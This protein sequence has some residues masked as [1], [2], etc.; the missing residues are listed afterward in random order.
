MFWW[1]TKTQR[2]ATQHNTTQHNTLATARFNEFKTWQ[3]VLNATGRPIALENC[4]AG[5]LPN[6]S[7]CPYTQWRTGGDPDTAGWQQEMMSTAQ[8]L[9]MARRGC[10]A[11]PG[12][13]IWSGGPAKSM[14][15][16][17]VLDWRTSF[18]AHCI[19]SSPLILSFDVRPNSNALDALWPV[20]AP[21]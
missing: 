2:N 1:C 21:R 7:W 17:E 16:S 20:G 14:S 10:W 15:S 8:K 6:A 4:H 3:R 11:Y 5:P 19:V 18:G 13:V 9:H 12:Y